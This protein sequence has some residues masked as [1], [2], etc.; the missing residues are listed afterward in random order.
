M[1]AAGN[2]RGHRRRSARHTGDATI[3]GQPV[4]RLS[5][6]RVG[7]DRRRRSY[8][9][10]SRRAEQATSEGLDAEQTIRAGRARAWDAG[11]V[12]AILPELADSRA[13][14][15]RSRSPSWPR[16]T[17]VHFSRRLARLGAQGH[18]ARPRRPAITR[19]SDVPLSL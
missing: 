17:M 16:E 12:A 19:R 6:V 4:G 15:G 11:A 7:L 18:R 3:L 10:G 1:A 2:R 8:S 9:V 5:D 13:S 14:I